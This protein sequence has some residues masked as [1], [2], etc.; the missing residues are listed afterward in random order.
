MEQLYNSPSHRNNLSNQALSLD[1]QIISPVH[2]ENLVSQL[3]NSNLY[4]YL[5]PSREWG[6]P[7]SGFLFTSGPP[8]PS[9]ALEPYWQSRVINSLTKICPAGHERQRRRNELRTLEQFV[10]MKCANADKQQRLCIVNLLLK[11][12]RKSFLC[13]LIFLF[14]VSLV[15]PNRNLLS[16]GA[17]FSYQIIVTNWILFK[18]SVL[19]SNSHY[20]A[21]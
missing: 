11:M 2:F 13:F 1:I 3:N 15:S 16:P 7:S 10:K 9:P 8:G 5:S 12:Q 21:V 6:P 20:N 17:R 18:P 14:K 4:T 19:V